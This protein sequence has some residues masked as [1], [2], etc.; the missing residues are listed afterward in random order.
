MQRIAIIGYGFAGRGFHA[1]LI[2]RVAGLAITAAVARD[3]ARQAEAR[4]DGIPAVFSSLEALLAAQV[5]DVVVLATPHDTHAEQAQ[6]ALAAGVG[7]V[8]DK[9]MCLSTAEADA[10]IAARDASGALLTVFHN[11][12]W[13]WDYLTVRD[14]MATGDLGAPY[15]FEV[16]VLRHKPPRGWRANATHGGGLLWDWGA[17]LVDHAL[18]LVPGPVAQVS[19]ELVRRGWGGDAGSWGRITL[20]FASGVLF[21]IEV[22]N[23]A[24]I[25]KPRWYVLGED[26]ALVKQGLDPQEPALL[27]GD[28]TQASEP[29]AHRARLVTAGGAERIVESLHGDWTGFYENLREVLAG[30]TPLAVTA[31]EARRV[32]AIL[33]AATRAAETG[34]PVDGPL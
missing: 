33:E 22:G 16:A 23:Q 15:L 11:R 26:G 8:I 1:P 21:A 13:D 2:R 5:A 4:A 31:E 18:Q 10:L 17:H 3:P 29:P 34:H 27:A 9:P 25:G 32:V 7:V 19:C 20:R 30:R 14:V 12:R 28:I 6:A 24:A